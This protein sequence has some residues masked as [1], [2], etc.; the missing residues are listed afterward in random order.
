VFATLVSPGAGGVP[1]RGKDPVKMS[2]TPLGTYRITFKHVAS[3]MSPERGENR[4]FWIADVP[5]TQYF[6]APFALHVAY[7]H[8]DFGK[9]MSAGCVNVSPRDGQHLFAWTEPVVPREWAGAGPTSLTG[10]GT[11]VVVTR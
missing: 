4:S 10:K 11:F 3:T 1:V 9:P 5:Y 8:E 6:N 7:W 2:T